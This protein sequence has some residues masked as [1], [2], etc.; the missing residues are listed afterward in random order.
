MTFSN[1]STGHDKRIRAD[2]NT[3]LIAYLSKGKNVETA[4][5]LLIRSD[6][7]QN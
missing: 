7:G 2:E 5:F 4:Y 6:N 3:R 1:G